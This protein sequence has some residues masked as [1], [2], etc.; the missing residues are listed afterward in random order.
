MDKYYRKK[1]LEDLNKRE[2]IIELTDLFI[3]ATVMV[4]IGLMVYEFIHLLKS[5]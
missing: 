4:I 1:L 3:L 5:L 2:S